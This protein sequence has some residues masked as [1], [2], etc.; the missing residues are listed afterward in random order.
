[1]GAAPIPSIGGDT[2]FTVIAKMIERRAGVTIGT[3]RKVMS[4]DMHEVY[5]IR[6][7]EHARM[8][9]GELHFRR[10]ARRDD[11][12]RLLRLGDQGAH[13]TFVVDTGFDEKAAKERGRKIITF[14]RRRA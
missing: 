11:L 5:A 9:S 14:R 1:M 12:D 6:Y 3:E 7:A 2:D 13:G 10:P 8:R 4:D